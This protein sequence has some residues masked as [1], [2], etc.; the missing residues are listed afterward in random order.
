MEMGRRWQAILSGL[1]VIPGA[2]GAVRREILESVGQI[3][4]DTVTEDFDMTIMLQKTKKKIAF[5]PKAIAWTHVPERW[6]DWIRQRIRWAAGQAQVYLK[7][8]DLFFKRRLGIFSFLIAPNNIFMDTIALFIRYLWLIA[9]LLPTVSSPIATLKLLL[10]ITF[11]YITIECIQLVSAA[12]IT[13]R[14]EE[15]KCAITA[16]LVIPYRELH[17]ITRFYAYTITLLRRKTQW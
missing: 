15:L 11:F 13:P 2:F 4:A 7:H 1:L 6:R 17:N 9:I 16:L 10:L 5:C 12:I 14:K 8:S 3:H